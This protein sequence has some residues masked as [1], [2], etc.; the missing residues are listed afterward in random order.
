MDIGIRA[1]VF[2]VNQ[3]VLLDSLLNKIE[4]GKLV[5]RG[6]GRSQ[7]LRE[8]KNDA[9]CGEGNANDEGDKVET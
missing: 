6:L 7:D 5:D 9:E 4:D 2:R 8:K 1:V 3:S